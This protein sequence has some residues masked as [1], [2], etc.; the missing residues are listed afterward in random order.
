M[1]KLRNYSPV[2]IVVND[3]KSCDLWTQVRSNAGCYTSVPD[4]LVYMKFIKRKKVLT[5]IKRHQSRSVGLQPVC[6][7]ID[8]GKVKVVP[9]LS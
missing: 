9:V 7:I 4:R 8:K 6:I 3:M 1:K 2:G 5:V